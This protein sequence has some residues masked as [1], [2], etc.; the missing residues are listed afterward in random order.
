MLDVKE[1]EKISNVE[2][3]LQRE[4][5]NINNLEQSMQEDKK[6][7]MESLEIMSKNFNAESIVEGS[8]MLPQFFK[9][10]NDS[11]DKANANI[12]ILKD[13][14]NS[15][16]SIM[17][18]ISM[19]TS[20]ENI[21]EDD[22]SNQLN[23]YNLKKMENKNE[24]LNNTTYVEKF[25]SSSKPIINSLKEEKV[26]SK[27]D[28]IREFKE[29]RK[30]QEENKEETIEENISTANK[31]ED[32]LY[33]PYKIQENNTLLISE[34]QEKIFLPYTLSDL[35]KYTV[36]TEK[37]L[38]D[39]VRENFIIPLH[40]FRNPTISRFK[41]TYNLARN[42]SNYSL[43][44]SFNFA[45]EVMFKRNLNPAIIVA[46]K[47]IDELKDY[48]NCL[49]EQKLDAFKAFNIKYEMNPMKI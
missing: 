26:A 12:N 2:N 36:D 45:V 47:N 31:N 34:K 28:I 17:F 37:S 18:T 43:F 9:S 21:D 15:I 42:K 40:T 49:K 16:N 7:L 25:I 29:K 10:L 38:E 14:E 1:Q 13:L 35:S 20:N 30:L 3:M 32:I 22:I 46:C 8:C 23:L 41:E 44:K 39:I 48:L 6:H 24:I 33:K 11:I 27:E 5:E 4:L 19:Q